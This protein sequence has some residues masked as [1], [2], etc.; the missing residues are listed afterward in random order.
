LVPEFLMCFLPGMFWNIMHKYY[1][2]LSYTPWKDCKNKYINLRITAVFFV[3]WL[4]H[5]NRF[6]FRDKL[7]DPFK[8]IIEEIKKA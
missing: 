4:L 3:K 6:L 8:P 5:R 7:M 2:Y 1:K